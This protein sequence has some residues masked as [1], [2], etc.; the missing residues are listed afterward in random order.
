MPIK[1][2]RDSSAKSR[3]GARMSVVCVKFCKIS[4]AA[5]VKPSPRDAVAHS[6]DMAGDGG[7]AC[8]SNPD[9]VETIRDMLDQASDQSGV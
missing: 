1:M 9:G 7:G 2:A 3:K 4:A 8:N 5:P 6:P